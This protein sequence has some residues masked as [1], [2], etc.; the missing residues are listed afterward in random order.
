MRVAR[1]Q[2]R[3]STRLRSVLALGGRRFS[4]LTVFGHVFWSLLLFTHGGVAMFSHV[5][6]PLTKRRTNPGTFAY[7]FGKAS[8]I[9]S[10]VKSTSGMTLE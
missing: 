6:D 1:P 9:T 8:V 4:S 10:A 3:P 5:G 2:R 7:N